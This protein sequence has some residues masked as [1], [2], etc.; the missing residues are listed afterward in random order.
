MEDLLGPDT[1]L[2]AVQGH[3]DDD[4]TG[5]SNVEEPEPHGGIDPD[6][7]AYLVTALQ[8]ENYGNM[9]KF[10]VNTE[11]IERFVKDPAGKVVPGK[12]VGDE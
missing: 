5:N 1:I 2:A 7:C 9:P 4:V 11:D 3:F 8:M 6:N 10:D 12:R